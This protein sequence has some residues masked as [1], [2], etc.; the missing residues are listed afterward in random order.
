[1]SN[2]AAPTQLVEDVPYRDL[3][4]MRGE[5][6]EFGAAGAAGGAAGVFG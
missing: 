6:G 5:V 2:Y 4:E 1:M 3:G